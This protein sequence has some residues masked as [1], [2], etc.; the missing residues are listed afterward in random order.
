MYGC[1]YESLSLQ[2][3][4]HIA[5]H[6]NEQKMTETARMKNLGVRKPKRTMRKQLAKT[7]PRSLPMASST[8]PS[9]PPL[10]LR[11]RPEPQ[12][13]QPP[14]YSLLFPP[15]QISL[16]QR[17]RQPLPSPSHT[18]PPTSSSPLPPPATSSGFQT[19]SSHAGL[20]GSVI[21]SECPVNNTFVEQQRP[22][23][24]AIAYEALRHLIST[25][26]DSVITSI[27][28]EQFA[29]EE[30]EL[31]IQDDE[32]SGI[33]GGWGSGSRQV[34]RGANRAISTAVVGTNHFA[35]ANLYANSRLPPNLP[36]LQL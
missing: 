21:S 25:K 34:S 32:Q 4:L 23:P 24:E 13:D 27:D 10:P 2:L 12:L 31:V 5:Y 33:R 6:S 29:G 15:E 1:Y 3:K 36:P 19:A 26:F 35:K 11:T 22:S 18:F 17:P 28:G 9:S 14:R 8:P 30:Q 20:A 16:P 7:S